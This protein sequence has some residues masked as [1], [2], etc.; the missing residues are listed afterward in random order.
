[1]KALTK[2]MFKKKSKDVEKWITSG[3]GFIDDPVHR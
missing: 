2:H 3:K 1:M